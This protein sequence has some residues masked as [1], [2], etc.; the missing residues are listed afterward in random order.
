MFMRYVAT[1]EIAVT[2][3]QDI[4]GYSGFYPRIN[5]YIVNCIRKKYKSSR[6]FCFKMLAASDPEEVW[7]VLLARILRLILLSD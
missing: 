6:K 1:R 5:G 3:K 7:N 4:P 2:S